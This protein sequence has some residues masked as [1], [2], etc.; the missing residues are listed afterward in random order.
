MRKKGRKLI[1]EKP[2]RTVYRD[3]KNGNGEEESVQTHA[4]VPRHPQECIS[5]GHL[6]RCNVEESTEK[7]AEGLHR[8]RI[9]N[10]KRIGG[11]GKIG[12]PI[13][14]PVG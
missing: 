9:R 4:K 3:R 12:V 7:E 10:T 5:D 1:T 13:K 2:Q 6:K 11:G 8:G 14:I